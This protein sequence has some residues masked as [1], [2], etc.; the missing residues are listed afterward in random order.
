MGRAK[1]RGAKFQSSPPTGNLTGVGKHNTASP[2]LKKKKRTY[3]TRAQRK[4][5]EEERWAKMAG[6]VTITQTKSITREGNNQ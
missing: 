5:R 1:R 3:L 4:R 2:S 6:P